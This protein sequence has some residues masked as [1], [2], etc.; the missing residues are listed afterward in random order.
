MASTVMEYKRIKVINGY[1]PLSR[2]QA[3]LSEDP[4]GEIPRSD[5]KTPYSYAP[6]HL[7]Y[8]WNERNVFICE[9]KHKRYEV[10][11]WTGK[12]DPLGTY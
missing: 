4:V 8:K 10:F 9:T 1:A 6:N 2:F 3:E 7:L 5:I 12:V 11:E